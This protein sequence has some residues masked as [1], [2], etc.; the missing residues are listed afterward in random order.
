MRRCVETTLIAR[1]CQAA[2]LLAV[3]GMVLGLLAQDMLRGADRI[4]VE[5]EASER[6][7]HHRI[8]QQEAGGH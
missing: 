6:S 3:L 5:R 8:L 2:S 7:L 4:T 1:V